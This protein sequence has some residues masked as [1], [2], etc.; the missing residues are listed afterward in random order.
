MED[1]RKNPPPGSVCQSFGEAICRYVR[2]VF[3]I[4][5]LC[6]LY[7]CICA[8]FLIYIYI[9]LYLFIYIFIY[10]YFYIYIHI[11]ICIYLTS[12]CIF[13]GLSAIRGSLWIGVS[14]KAPPPLTAEPP[15][16]PPVD[17]PSNDGDGR[18]SAEQAVT[19]S[20]VPPA[21]PA[22]QSSSSS[23]SPVETHAATKLPDQV[24]ELKTQHLN[25][26]LM[27]LF[28]C[29]GVRVIW[30]IFFGHILQ[31][32]PTNQVQCLLWEKRYS[33]VHQSSMVRHGHSSTCCRHI[34]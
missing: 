18:V 17:S 27:D 29:R 13:A 26:Y 28:F 7:I 31:E 8:P 4:Q 1:L 14:P 30:A 2:V 21:N 15:L 24:K 3:G 16:P 6:I 11:Y 9:Y 12:I 20:V 33:Q 19:N 25:V 34:L 10:I 32:K 5:C 23:S 22:A